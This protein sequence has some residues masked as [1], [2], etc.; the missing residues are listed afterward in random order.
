MCRCES[1]KEPEPE[2]ATVSEEPPFAASVTALAYLRAVEL[3]TQIGNN[4]DKLLHA[5]YK[6]LFSGL[7]IKDRI[8]SFCSSVSCSLE[9]HLTEFLN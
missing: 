2:R 6:L 9:S 4:K 8:L 1:A 3:A 7:K 5:K